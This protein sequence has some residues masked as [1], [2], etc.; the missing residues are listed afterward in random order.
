MAFLP[1]FSNIVHKLQVEVALFNQL[2]AGLKESNRKR[3]PFNIVANNTAVV[4][5]VC[6]WDGAV[7]SL[8]IASPS[9]A[10][11]SSSGNTVTVTV[12]DKNGAVTL[13]T[14]DTF[15]NTQELAVNTGAAFFNAGPA[16]SNGARTRQFLAGDVITVTATV[17]GTPGI[18]NAN[19]LNVVLTLT[20]TDP[21]ASF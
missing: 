13:F 20:P 5:Y 7:E 14:A 17:T 10:T 15:A 4:E 11:T 9:G 12:I 2:K 8:I 16:M 3:I 6:P 21:K 19:S 18:S 1:S